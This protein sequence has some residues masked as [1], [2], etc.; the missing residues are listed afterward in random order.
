MSKH[1]F[2][3]LPNL[4]Y[5]NQLESSIT[6]NNYV[7]TKNLFLRA[8]IRDSAATDV[9]FLNSYTIKEGVR[10]DEV[11]DELYGN[12]EL[13]WIILTVANITNVRSE[14]PM[15]SKVLYDY[16]VSKYGVDKDETQFYETTLVKDS[17]GRLILPAGLKVDSNFTI[18]HPDTH[19]ITLNPVIGISNYLAETREN[20]KKR[21]IKV[22]RREFMTSFMMDMKQA[23]EYTKSS[24]YESK[25]MKVANNPT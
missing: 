20:E 5:K 23:L 19:N 9:T 18:P 22:M 10:P 1:Y 16:C 2:R 12:P 11:A 13:D 14:W 25:T 4:R 3:N 21:N 8:K 6:R 7:T 15:G 24:Q 17:Q